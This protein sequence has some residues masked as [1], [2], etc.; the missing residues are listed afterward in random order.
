MNLSV[1]AQVVISLQ[2]SKRT[3]PAENLT[4]RLSPADRRPDRDTQRLE[5][6]VWAPVVGLLVGFGCFGVLLVLGS[7]MGFLDYRFIAAMKPSPKK[8]KKPAKTPVRPVPPT[9][10]ADE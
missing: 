8:S 2:H 9:R 10:G 7:L 5:V 1:E 6:P 4:I 3:L